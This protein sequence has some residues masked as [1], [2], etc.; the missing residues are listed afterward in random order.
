VI[1]RGDADQGADTP[2]VGGTQFL[3]FGQQCG[4]DHGADAGNR[5]QELVGRIE[6]IVRFDQRANLPVQLANLLAE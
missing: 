3:Q 6:V 4:A 1:V 2:A 5:L